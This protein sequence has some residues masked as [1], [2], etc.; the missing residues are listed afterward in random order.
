MAAEQVLKRMRET[1]FF[2]VAQAVLDA[3]YE[4]PETARWSDLRK[5]ERTLP[6]PRINDLHTLVP[7]HDWHQG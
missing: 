3:F 5:R 1:A 6:N 2:P 7:D 4:P